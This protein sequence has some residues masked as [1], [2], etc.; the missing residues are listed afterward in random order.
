MGR[1]KLQ[2]KEEDKSDQDVK[3]EDDDEEED[4]EKEEDQLLLKKRRDRKEEDTKASFFI[5]EITDQYLVSS[6]IFD[7]EIISAK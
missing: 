2:I 3:V 5:I 1:P 4:E 6:W 7:K